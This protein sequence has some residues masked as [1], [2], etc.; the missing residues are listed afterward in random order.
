MQR[1]FATIPTRD[2]LSSCS[3]VS[4]I[5]NAEAR[6]FVRDSRICAAK[7]NKETTACEFMQNL[8]ALCGQMK[9]NGRFV[10]FNYLRI[11]F[12]KQCT[13]EKSTGDEILY[14]NVISELELTGLSVT[15]SAF[16][17]C[18]HHSPLH[19]VLKHKSKDLRTLKVDNTE[20]FS[21]FGFGSTSGWFPH[22][23]K[24][25]ELRLEELSCSWKDISRFQWLLKH[26]P[27]L[28]RIFSRGLY[29]LESVSRDVLA[30]VAL[31]GKL[32]T[33]GE[34]NDKEVDLLSAI[35][36]RFSGLKELVFKEVGPNPFDF[37][38]DGHKY[39]DY[40]PPEGR[41]ELEKRRKRCKTAL[42]KLLQAAQQSLE[43]MKTNGIYHLSQFSHPPLTN[44]SKL[45]LI[46]RT[47]YDWNDMA[48]MDFQR[49]M[50]SLKEVGMR[51]E[52]EVDCERLLYGSSTVRELNLDLRHDRFDL[53]IL[54]VSENA[55][56]CLRMHVSKGFCT[57][58]TFEGLLA[59]RA[60]SPTTMVLRTHS[61]SL[62]E[63]ATAGRIEDD[64]TCG[65]H[66][67]KL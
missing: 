42:E 28:K 37:G 44:L 58:L 14:S 32:E 11:N 30:R 36:D 59:V 4:K 60:A 1:V 5:W 34:L 47:W 24:L 46:L 35:A 56:V 33:I 12:S 9:Q 40:E 8:D 3:L 63:L 67:P 16:S 54:G 20:P 43:I 15:G 39:F 22:F 13:K 41:V 62:C 31:H 65:L 57:Q 53:R 51:I 26:A 7:N 29:C 64:G 10:P 18:E 61:S 6:K 49:S 38:E 21:R 45:G 50:P 2:L 48:S 23:A 19:M 66:E 25:E 55:N 17:D 52:I 27:N